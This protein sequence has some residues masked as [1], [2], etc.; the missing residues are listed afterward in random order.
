VF[1]PEDGSQPIV[2]PTGV[3]PDKKWLWESEHEQWPGITF[4]WMDRAEV[5]ID[6]QRRAVELSDA[7]Y[8][9]L[10]T[11]WFQSMGGRATP[12]E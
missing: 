2:F 4:T 9:K 1:H 7:E 3:T 12:G 8:L 11:Q 5:P 10:I 6:M